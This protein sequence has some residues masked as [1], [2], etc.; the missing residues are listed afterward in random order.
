ML[1]ENHKRGDSIA[2]TEG[3][4]IAA[5]RLSGD[6]L[7]LSVTFGD[8]SPKGR[9][10]RHTARLLRGLHQRTQ[11]PQHGI[12]QRAWE[13]GAAV[14]QMHLAAGGQGAEDVVPEDG[15]LAVVEQQRPALEVEVE[16]AVVHV[17]AAHYGGAVIA[18]VAL[19]VEEAGAEL[20]DAHPARSRGR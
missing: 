8:T 19:G 2:L 10:F 13:G 20:V 5:Q 4:L 6:E 1:T 18:D 11:Q 17:D 14:G 12:Q 16:A 15:D 3:L 9:G 7:A